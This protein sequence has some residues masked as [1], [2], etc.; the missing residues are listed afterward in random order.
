MPNRTYA[1]EWI[2]KACRNLKAAHL[3]YEND[4][5]T[6]VIG[7]ELHYAVEK[8][9]KTIMAYHNRKIVKKHDLVLLYS[10]VKED[11]G[12][13]DLSLLE[14]VNTFFQ[15]ERYPN[16]A[17]TLPSRESIRRGLELADELFERVCK[18]F[19]LDCKDCR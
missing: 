11:L 3:L 18:K 6:D 8:L 5:Y 4:F 14:E 15:E 17:Y 7:I 13:L 12:D 10:Y 9:F 16:V 2:A 19:E 1:N